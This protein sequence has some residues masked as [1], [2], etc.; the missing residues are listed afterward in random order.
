MN[1]EKKNMYR[2]M[3]VE[4]EPLECIV[5]EEILK[6]QYAEI[7]KIDIAANGIDALKWRRNICPIFCLWISM[8][9]SFPGW[10]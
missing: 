9:L 10:K 5:L 8:F 2:V 6:T 4:D 3:I 7:E 1:T